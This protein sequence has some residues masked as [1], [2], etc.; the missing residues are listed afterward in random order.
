MSFIPVSYLQDGN[1]NQGSL[2]SS[3]SLLHSILVRRE[4]LISSWVKKTIN[5]SG[6]VGKQGRE[7]QGR[8]SGCLHIT[9][10]S[11]A[12]KEKPSPHTI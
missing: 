5:S 3:F 12:G 4:R 10:P 7:V 1:I 9:L 6:N 8:N 2:G 11:K